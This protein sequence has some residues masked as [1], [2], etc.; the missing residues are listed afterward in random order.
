[1]SALHFKTVSD[2]LKEPAKDYGDNY[3]G[4]AKQLYQ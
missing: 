1:M 2:I 3:L 4:R